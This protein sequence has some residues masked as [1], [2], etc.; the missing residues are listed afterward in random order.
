MSAQAPAL[1]AACQTEK[2]FD[3]KNSLKFEVTYPA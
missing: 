3:F 2:K 1:E